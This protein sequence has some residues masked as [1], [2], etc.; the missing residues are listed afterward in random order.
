MG[1]RAANARAPRARAR[2]RRRARRHAAPRRHRLRQIDPIA[3][4]A[5]RHFRAAVCAR[6]AAAAA[7]RRRARR[8]RGVGLG[9]QKLVGY[10]IRGESRKGS[11]VEFC[12]TGVSA[13]AARGRRLARWRDAL[14][15]GRGASGRPKLDLALAAIR[16][17]HAATPS[18]APLPCS[19]RPPSSRALGLVLRPSACASARSDV[20]GRTF[21]VE[22]KY[23]DDVDAAAARRRR[24]RSRVRRRRRR[25][26][27]RRSARGRPPPPVA[28]A[29][30]SERARKA[31]AAAGAE[32]GAAR[33]DAVDDELVERLVL[34]HHAAGGGAGDGAVLVF[35]PGVAEISALVAR[36]QTHTS[37]LP[38][39]LHSG[40]QTADQ[41]QCFQRAP[42][43]RTK[44][45]VATDIAEASV[46]IPDVTLVVDCGLHRTVVS[47]ERTGVASLVTARV[48]RAAAQQRAGRAG[49]VRAGTAIHLFR[50]A[51][52]ETMAAHPTAEVLRAPLDAI[53]LR[54]RVLAGDAEAGA[55]TAAPDELLRLPA[56]A[57]GDRAAL[58]ALGALARGGRRAA[59]AVWAAPPLPTSPAHARA[60]HCGGAWPLA[61]RLD[62]RGARAGSRLAVGRRRRRRQAR[63]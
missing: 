39:P 35:L 2:N 20:P 57:A 10:S 32:A 36:L 5:A 55:T 53:V 9:E 14:G 58:I 13:A 27:R 30:L 26:R 23:I 44:V 47:D 49:R 17:M 59:D 7:R 38:L 46:T 11:H 22:Q 48:S 1:H 4:A 62:R 50:R 60:R 8:A 41:R 42:A 63:T 51:E 40:L 12:T 54:A 45:V 34:E 52:L 15:A 28:K 18:A 56:A 29:N 16:K 6:R 25:R 33:A 21:P 31:E 24:R 43:R 61:R 3:A 19:C 37:L